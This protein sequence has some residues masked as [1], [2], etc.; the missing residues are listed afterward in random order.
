MKRLAVAV[1][2]A[3]LLAGCTSGG[4]SSTG[5]S[6]ALTPV[7]SVST[8]PYERDGTIFIRGEDGSP[9]AL[10]EGFL[11]LRSPDHATIAFLRDRLAPHARDSGDPYVLQLWLIHP[12][13]SGL[14]KLG[15]ERGCCIGASPDLYWSDDSGTIVFS[16][17]RSQTIDVATGE[18]RPTDPT[19]G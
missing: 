17:V 19:D 9:V 4:T 10:T 16:G 15:H 3:C 12:D 1:M 5:S 6:T 14:R 18:S 8:S 7:L 11:P 2:I 13:G